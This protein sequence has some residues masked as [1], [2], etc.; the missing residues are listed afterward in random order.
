MMHAI[1]RISWPKVQ[2]KFNATIVLQQTI[3]RKYKMKKKTVF[4]EFDII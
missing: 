2:K 3:S 1:N 4:S